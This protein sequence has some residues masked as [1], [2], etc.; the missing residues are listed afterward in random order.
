MRSSPACAKIRPSSTISRPRCP[1]GPA[2]ASS[3]LTSAREA[4]IGL[5]SAGLE[6]RASAGIDHDALAA[7]RRRAV[8]VGATPEIAAGLGKGGFTAAWNEVRAG[9]RERRTCGFVTGG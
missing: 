6:G 8:L 5:A 1:S 4:E 3:L 2:P 7:L 9:R